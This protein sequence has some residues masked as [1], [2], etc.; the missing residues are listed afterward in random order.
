MPVFLSFTALVV[1]VQIVVCVAIWLLTLMLSPSFEPLF[2]RMVYFHW[3]AIILVSKLPSILVGEP[4]MNGTVVI[5][6]LLGVL[7][8]AAVFGC[9]MSLVKKRYIANAPKA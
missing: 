3:P 8:Y 9:A 6:R 7:I 1:V 4:G 5:A 2:E